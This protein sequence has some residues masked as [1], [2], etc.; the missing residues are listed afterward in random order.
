MKNKMLLS[1]VTTIENTY[2]RKISGAPVMYFWSGGVQ[3]WGR[4]GFSEEC[5]AAGVKGVKHMGRRP[6]GQEQVGKQRLYIDRVSAFAP[7]CSHSRASL[8]GKGS[9]SKPWRSRYLPGRVESD[10]RIGYVV[11]TQ[12]T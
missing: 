11:I 2:V 10:T 4:R 6:A 12:Q 1:T 3:F 9:L 7:Q 8:R 5:F